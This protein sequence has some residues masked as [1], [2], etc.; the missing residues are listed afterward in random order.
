MTLKFFSYIL[1]LLRNPVYLFDL[2]I[3]TYWLPRLIRAVSYLFRSIKQAIKEN[4]SKDWR[5][6]EN[7]GHTFR[8]REIRG[9]NAEVLA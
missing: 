1:K 2:V 3:V 7:N 9:A 5:E 8:G 6:A 4:L